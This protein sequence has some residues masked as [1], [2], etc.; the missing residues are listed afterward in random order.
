MRT[1]GVVSHTDWAHVFIVDYKQFD[2]F[3]G[4]EGVEYIVDR[5][6]YGGMERLYWR[7]QGGP[8]TYHNTRI[9]LDG[10]EVSDFIIHGRY[11]RRM[12]PFRPVYNAAFGDPGTVSLHLDADEPGRARLALRPDAADLEG[13]VTIEIR[14]RVT[15]DAEPLF[16]FDYAD[17][18]GG[19]W[20]LFLSGDGELSNSGGAALKPRF[21]EHFNYLRFVDDGKGVTVYI[22]QNAEEKLELLRQPGAGLSFAVSGDRSKNGRLWVDTLAV[23]S[24]AMAPPLK[25]PYEDWDRL[26]ADYGAAPEWHQ[27]DWSKHWTNDGFRIATDRGVEHGRIDF[28]GTYREAPERFGE[29]EDVLSAAMKAGKA[30]DLEMFAWFTIGE[31]NHFGSGPMSRFVTLHPELR[32]MDRRGRAWRGRLSFAHPEVREHKLS[33]IREVV[34]NYGADGILL[35]FVR[36]GLLDPYHEDSKTTHHPV[37]DADGVGIFGYDKRT[38]A[39]YR[40]RYG[41]DPSE[42]ANDTEE[43]IQFRADIWTDFFRKIRVEFPGVPVVAMVFSYDHEKARRGDF[44]DWGKWVD[45]GLVD[46]MAFLIDNADSGRPF[47]APFGGQPEPLE[48]VETIVRERK[49]RVG[50]RADVIAAVYGYRIRPE[51]V[52][53]ITEYAHR[54]GADELM[55]WETS[56]L[57]WA[58]YSGGV[59]NTVREL[60][61]RY[62][63]REPADGREFQPGGRW[64]GIRRPTGAP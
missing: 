42:I 55:W 3:W 22:N 21:H 37:W 38:R 48:S 18:R 14:V 49:K 12:P 26:E 47:V 20:R 23:T 53:Q 34:N 43:W 40:A 57:E 17:G 44:L 41:V 1:S 63:G 52:E 24:G 64:E 62:S 56:P 31:E 11:S 33:L 50:D 6:R 59:W 7:I 19:A 8:N 60:S 25:F 2:R 39:E 27:D 61:A 35:D 45:E 32:E 13:P 58:D 15:G 46:G 5:S 54:G 51:Q 30:R 9:D 16:S 4:S 28:A 29:G 36:R 10:D